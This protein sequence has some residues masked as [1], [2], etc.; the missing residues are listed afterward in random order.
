M[1]YVVYQL[2][3]CMCVYFLKTLVCVCICMYLYIKKD[4]QSAKTSQES[5]MGEITQGEYPLQCV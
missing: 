2:T 5:M 4:N 1:Y 3:P